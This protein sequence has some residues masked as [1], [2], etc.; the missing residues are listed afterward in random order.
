[1]QWRRKRNRAAGRCRGTDAE[2]DCCERP[3][4]LFRFARR[5]G[6]VRDR[7]TGGREARMPRSGPAA[8]HAAPAATRVRPRI[9]SMPPLGMISGRVG[10]QASGLS[11]YGWQAPAWDR[12]VMSRPPPAPEAPAA[13]SLLR[14]LTSASQDE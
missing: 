12:P 7:R 13:M 14:P 6:L 5:L 8:A 4:G 3:A 10:S 1:R 9:E 11:A 2:M